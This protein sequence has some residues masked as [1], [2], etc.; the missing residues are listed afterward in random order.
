MATLA[1]FNCAIR[2]S[3]ES[4]R[5]RNDSSR[6]EQQ[7]PQRQPENS[8][9]SEKDDETTA[10]SCNK[11]LKTCDYPFLVSSSIC[12]QDN[13]YRIKKTFS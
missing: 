8:Y 4:E 10:A 3:G 13:V 12:R 1:R 6:P 9:D 7:F 5:L 2:I 11:L